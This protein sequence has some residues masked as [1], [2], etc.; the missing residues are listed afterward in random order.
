VFCNSNV[1]TADDLMG[2][3]DL[4]LDQITNAPRPEKEEEE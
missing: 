3:R 4:V 2:L 1:V